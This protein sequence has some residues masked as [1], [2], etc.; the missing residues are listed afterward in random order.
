V[1]VSVNT[2]PRRS[3]L[4]A[5]IYRDALLPE[6]EQK[7]VRLR[8]TERLETWQLAERFGVS[9][10]RIGDILTRAGCGHERD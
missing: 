3:R 8:R 9:I 10:S 5:R 2:I 6:Q 1:S 7:I 4:S